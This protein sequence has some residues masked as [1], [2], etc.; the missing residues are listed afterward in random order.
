VLRLLQLQL[1]DVCRGPSCGGQELVA[2]GPLCARPAL[3]THPARQKPVQ[4]A[5]S[6]LRSAF[7]G[8]SLLVLQSLLGQVLVLLLDWHP[9]GFFRKALPPEAGQAA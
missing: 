2:Y 8:P 5:E 3:Q 9:A 4:A 7:L 6:V 1:L